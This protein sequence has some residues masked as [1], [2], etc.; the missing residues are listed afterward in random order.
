MYQN[1]NKLLFSGP[2]GDVRKPWWSRETGTIF[3][4]H[5]R[6][7]TWS[8][9]PDHLTSYDHVTSWC[10]VMTKIVSGPKY[11]V[12]G[13][14]KCDYRGFE[15]SACTNWSTRFEMCYLKPMNLFDVW[16]LISLKNLL[17]VCSLLMICWNK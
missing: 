14:R 16:Y 15:S 4:C 17:T 12:L 8:S 9:K 7:T 2:S 3:L 1:D 11:P 10:D 6:V 13:S 5:V